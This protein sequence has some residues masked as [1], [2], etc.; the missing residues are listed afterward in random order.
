MVGQNH[1]LDGHE[2]GQTPGDSEGQGGLVCCSPWG[3]KESDTTQR[4]NN[5]KLIFKL[6]HKEEKYLKNKGKEPQSLMRQHQTNFCITEIS[7]GGQKKIRQR[8]I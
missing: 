4:L 3:Y 6:K 8:H 1:G 7:E 2:L 5:N